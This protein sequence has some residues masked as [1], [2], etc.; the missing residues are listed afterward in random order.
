MG[1]YRRDLERAHQPEPGHIGRRDGG[2]VLPFVQNP[3]RRGLQKLGEQVEARGLAG[4]VRADQR[5]NAATADLQCDIANGKEP[6][7]FLGQSVGFEN[8]LVGQ[9]I[10]PCRARPALGSLSSHP[11]TGR[12]PGTSW[13]VPRSAPAGAEYAV[14]RGS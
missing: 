10:S 9:K 4:P 8:E 6:R 14:I 13:T 11:P 3:S 5:V 12:P 1:K 7:E 2:N